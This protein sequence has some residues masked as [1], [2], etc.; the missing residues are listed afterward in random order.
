MDKISGHGATK[1]FPQRG[2]PFSRWLGRTVLSLSGW[3]IEGQIPA[4]PKLLVVVAPH[5]SN[6][7]FFIGILVVFRLGLDAHWIAKHTLFESPL[8]GVLRWLGG[9]PVDRRA[10]H[11]VVNQLVDVYE[12]QPQLLL[13]ITPEGTRKKVKQW[14]SGFHHIA[15]RAN[16]PLV[17]ATIDYG[18]KT[19]RIYPVVALSGAYQHDLLTVQT[20]FSDV[21]PRHPQNY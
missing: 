2:N 9:I 1:G 8:G 4:V 21:V 10:A 13:A 12:K 19:V 6:W 17:P 16:V 14:K 3:K 18:C 11:G 7:D 15:I 20:L 5:T